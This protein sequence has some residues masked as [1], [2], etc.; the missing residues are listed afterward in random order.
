MK[1]TVAAARDPRWVRDTRVTSAKG[2][3]ADVMNAVLIRAAVAEGVSGVVFVVV[4]SLVVPLLYDPKD[5]AK[6]IEYK[7]PPLKRVN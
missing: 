2:Q 4:P 7:L 3:E 1:K 5:E 6:S